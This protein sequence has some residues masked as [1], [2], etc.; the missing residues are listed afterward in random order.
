M[1]NR[2]DFYQAD[3]AC[4]AIGSSMP[5]VFINGC[6]CD[7]IEVA[8][9]VRGEMGEYGWAKLRLLGGGWGELYL[10]D[11]TAMPRVGRSVDIVSVYPGDAEGQ[12][13]AMGLFS[14]QIERIEGELGDT[15]VV[16]VVARDISA[17]L[18][19]IRVGGRRVAGSKDSVRVN[20]LEL[21][22]G[23]N[24]SPDTVMWD[25][26]ASRIFT[27]EDGA[28]KSWSCAEAVVYLLSE[29]VPFGMLE[30]GP[31]EHIDA[32]MLSAVCDGIDV[33]GLTLLDSIEAVCQAANVKF[34]FVSRFGMDGSVQG[35]VFY[36][37]GAGRCVELDM[38]RA[39]EVLSL[40]RTQAAKLKRR[41]N[42]WPLTRRYTA[43]GELKQFEA[44]FEMVS[45]WDDLLEGKTQAEYATDHAEFDS[46][47]DVYRKW[48]LNEAGDHS[49]AVYDF[50]K[51][52]G[53]GEYVRRRRRFLDC[54]SVD[55]DGNSYGIHV[56]VSY[57]SGVN[58]QVFDGSVDNLSDQC[59][60]WV[61]DSELGGDY[62]TAADSGQ[63]CLRV[64]ATVASDERI[65][66]TVADGPVGSSAEVVDLLVKTDGIYRYE[67]VTGRSI[68][69][70]DSVG[71]DDSERLMSAVRDAANSDDKTIEEIEIC[72]PVLRV[73][74]Q[75]G[76]CVV[77]AADG[78]N[79][80]GELHDGRSE[81]VIERVA[82]DV[83]MQQTRLKI[84]R[85]R[86]FEC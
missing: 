44:T 7:D 13:C 48:C 14:G 70:R 41:G 26:K 33:E 46:V 3:R 76:D 15:N 43:M 50:S 4:L 31:V 28:G 60:I 77:S 47:R 8:E 27:A 59:G 67:C 23:E 83:Q 61:S 19:R 65:G 29:F 9:I 22:F 81:F 57:D 10:D 35:A 1:S 66:C 82:V 79:V 56:E 52:F 45:A 38:Q 85:R 11:S 36:R 37:P 39:G 64:T 42:V 12:V 53:D 6:L 74:Y 24:A 86:G 2:I 40:S 68:F 55:G 16:E 18:S 72:T 80:L 20:G 63:L 21:V 5:V 30:V 54:I 84:V 49:G 25:G 51:V 69:Y 73:G 32:I 71:F 78:R 75:P 58:W 62:F 17:R 34:R